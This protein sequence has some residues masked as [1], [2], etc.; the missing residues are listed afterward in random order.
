MEHIKIIA[1]SEF[2]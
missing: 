2:H 1:L